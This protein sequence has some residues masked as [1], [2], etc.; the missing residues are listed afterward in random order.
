MDGA[1]VALVVANDQYDDPGLRQL[2]A[3]AQD[4]ATAFVGNALVIAAVLSRALRLPSR[5]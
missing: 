4:A 1:R 2:V 5:P 3:P